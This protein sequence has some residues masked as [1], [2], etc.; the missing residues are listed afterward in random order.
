MDVPFPIDH[1]LYDSFDGDTIYTTNTR[2][3]VNNITN[4]TQIHSMSFKKNPIISQTSDEKM[5]SMGNQ[6]LKSYL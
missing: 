4:S 3:I 6:I 2:F 5:V 1:Y